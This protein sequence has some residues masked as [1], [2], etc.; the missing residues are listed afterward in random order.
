MILL[1]SNKMM[2]RFYIGLILLLLMVAGG[3]YFYL[4]KMQTYQG[5]LNIN[6]VEDLDTFY[7]RSVY[8]DYY[9]RVI[10][11]DQDNSIIKNFINEKI[12]HLFDDTIFVNGYYSEL[13]PVKIAMG[14]DFSVSPMARFT[15]KNFDL[16]VKEEMVSEVGNVSD[17]NNAY[18]DQVKNF[19]EVFAKILATQDQDYFTQ[20]R[21]DAENMIKDLYGDMNLSTNLETIDKSFFYELVKTPINNL[22]INYL[23]LKYFKLV[24]TISKKEWSPF[25][26]KWV[27]GDSKIILQYRRK[28]TSVLLRN[29][30]ELVKSNN[31]EIVINTIS[32]NE[33]MTV[34]VYLKIDKPNNT[35]SSY[36]MSKD[37][38][39]YVLT[40]KADSKQTLITTLHD[41]MKIALGIYFD[42]KPTNKWFINELAEVKKY[43]GL[44]RDDDL[45]DDLEKL[46]D[47]TWGVQLLEFKN[48]FGE[49]PS[50]SLYE[51]LID[52]K[53]K[54]SMKNKMKNY[55]YKIMD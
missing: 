23:K 31:D 30:N 39:L 46:N 45:A 37:G 15:L 7:A 13:M 5:G 41:F 10:D 27:Y 22:N 50:K 11:Y 42:E 24:Q 3:G 4:S 51:K 28:E 2:V 49:Y 25:I 6:K 19:K 17:D 43:Y 18:I 36:H 29:L 53:E 12:Y 14:Y 32:I 55:F 9:F 54:K 20:S 38:Y 40:M 21:K 44:I 35:V 16:P 26:A 8:G 47:K 52:E 34:P 48:R 33:N 1:A